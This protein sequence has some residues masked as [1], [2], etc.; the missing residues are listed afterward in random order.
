MIT[1]SEK[2]NYV[3]GDDTSFLGSLKAVPHWTSHAVAS[4]QVCGYFT[5][6]VPGLSFGWGE[7]N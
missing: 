6:A 4:L 3:L 5:G 2:C 1:I 7:L